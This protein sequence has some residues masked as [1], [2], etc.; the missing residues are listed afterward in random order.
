MTAVLVAVLMSVVLLV[1]AAFAVDLGQQRVVRRDMQAVADV[2]AMDVAW[3]LDGRTLKT[4]MTNGVI[5]DAVNASLARNRD[6]FGADADVTWKVGKVDA[7]GDF[8]AFSQPADDAESPSAVRVLAH[9]STKFSFGGMTG[10][11]KG[12]ATRSAVTSVE[13]GACF[14]VGTYAARIRLGDGTILGPL[15]KALGTD[16]GLNVL[17]AQGLAAAD[18]KLLDLVNTGLIAGGFD[19]FVDASVSLGT[20]YLAMAQVLQNQGGHAAQVALLQKLATVAA[21]DII[22]NVADIVGLDTTSSAALDATV[23]VFDLVSTAA[24]VANGSN[25]ILVPNLNV[26]VVGLSTLTGSVKIGQKPIQYCGRAKSVETKGHSNQVEVNL[27]GNLA[28]LDL[29]LVSISAPITLTL[30]LT[31]ADVSLDDVRC[32]TDKKILDFVT[33]SGLVSLEVT[34]GDPA[35][36]NNLS[37]KALLGLVKLVDGYIRLYS[38]PAPAA[39]ETKSATVDL[40]NYDGSAPVEF[41]TDSLG[42]P[43]LNQDTHLNV[44]GILPVGGLLGAVVT[45]LL[46]LVVNPLVAALDN[47]LLTPL[48]KALGINVAGAEVYAKKKADCGIPQLVG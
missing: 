33:T 8:V 25:A 29:G 39:T 12:D 44:L 14:T 37:V 7:A 4:L 31:P 30:K 6:S 20:F 40:E 2:V 42:V 28:N 47:V 11:S 41:G 24:F 1:S 5:S 13:K 3:Q 22:V 48:L 46:S 32:L 26:N 17:D 15:V 19:D 27:R 34:V 21:K 9:S 18:I 43:Y 38:T 16:V 10:R 45:P 36:R 35:N 23:N